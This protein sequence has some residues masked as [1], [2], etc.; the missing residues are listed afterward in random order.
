MTLT[1]RTVLVATG[2]ALLAPARAQ[3]PG[4][5]RRALD[6]AADAPPQRA[7]ALLDGVIGVTPAER[8]DLTAAREGLAIDALLAR[9]P[10]AGPRRFKLLLHRQ[11][12]NIDLTVAQARIEQEHSRIIARADR[13]FRLIGLA[14]GS[15]GSRYRALWHED[16]FLYSDGPDGRDR[17]IVDMNR[18]LAAVVPRLA[19][20]FGELP[21]ASLQVTASRMSR[22][23]E[24]SRRSGYRVPPS[25]TAPGGYFVDLADIRRRP[26]WS[27]PS[28]VHHELLPGH[29]IHLPIEAAAN[30]HPLRLRYASAFAEG[31]AIYA[32]QLAADD[33][34]DPHIM[35]GHLHWLLFRLNRARVDLGIHLQGWSVAQARDRLEEWQGEPAYFAPFE[36]D[37][38]RIAAEPAIRTAEAIAWLTIADKARRQPRAR[39][40]DFHRSLLANG[41]LRLTL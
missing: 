12:G 26:S 13:C 6:A 8:L 14:Q 27:L 1:R 22:G 5:V 24:A 28:V 18:T 34:D 3:T 36:S 25:P 10:V 41:R 38:E 33:R 2:A 35:L 20:W 31:W 30:P 15:V 23:D 16:R 40:R 4:V 39:L 32:E 7:L 21:H 37:L 9:A 11:V 29:M 19:G 17:A